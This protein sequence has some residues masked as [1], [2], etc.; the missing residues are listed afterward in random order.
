MTSPGRSW[1]LDT[2]C[3]AGEEQRNAPP[4]A[5]LPAC[6]SWC[7]GEPGHYR[8]FDVGA[9]THVCLVGELPGGGRV[10]LSAYEDTTRTGVRRI[11]PTRVNLSATELDPRT[12][13]ALRK[14]LD[15]AEA[16]LREAGH[17]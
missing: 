17:Q 14:L 11:H 10:G 15:Q 13:P 1:K 5:D 9:R 7:D 8:P 6:P 16:K 12:L 4:P 3:K 2:L